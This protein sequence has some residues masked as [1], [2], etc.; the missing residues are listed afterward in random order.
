VWN[1]KENE[2]NQKNTRTGPRAYNFHTNILAV[3]HAI[4]DEAEEL[5]YKRN[6]FIVVSYKWSNLGEN[7]GGLLWLPIVS[8]QHAGRMRLHSLRIHVSGVGGPH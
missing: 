8:N 4:H 5:M 7:I 6:T 2:D 1:R 3:N